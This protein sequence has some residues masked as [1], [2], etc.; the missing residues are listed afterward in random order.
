MTCD[1][2]RNRTGFFPEYDVPGLVALLAP[3]TGSQARVG[4]EEVQAMPGQGTRSM[5]QVGFGFGVWLGILGALGLAY[6]RTGPTSGNAAW[7]S[8]GTKNRHDCAPCSSSLVPMCAG[9]A[10][11]AEPRHYWGWQHQCQRD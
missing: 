4:L 9:S 8:P 10:T 5:F 1:V 6:A 7:G 11:M 2:P 3:S